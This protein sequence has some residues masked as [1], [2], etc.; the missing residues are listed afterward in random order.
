MQLFGKAA[1]E[2]H[3]KYFRMLHITSEQAYGSKDQKA[4]LRF[5]FHLP[6]PDRMEELTR[7]LSAA[8]AL[9]DIVGAYKLSPDMK[10]RAEKVR[11]RPLTPGLLCMDEINI[12]IPRT[13]DG[14]MT[15]RHLFEYTLDCTLP[16][17][18]MCMP[19]K[20]ALQASAVEN[21][22]TS[23]VLN[24]GIPCQR[25]W[26]LRADGLDCALASVLMGVWGR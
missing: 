1:W 9:I 24:S 18:S 22:H 6:P 21:F 13:S 20:A 12:F 25:A 7:L 3:G 26:E 10:K 8:I 15:V 19:S 5:S 23:F 14:L 2:A 16:W 17:S 11:Q 4:V